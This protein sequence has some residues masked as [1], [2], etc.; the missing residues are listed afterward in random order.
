MRRVIAGPNAAAAPLAYARG[1][2]GGPRP[3]LKERT[4]PGIRRSTIVG[5]TIGAAQN[6]TLSVAFT[7]MPWTAPSTANGW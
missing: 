2:I 5:S 3:D 1:R 6:V 4:G 7:V